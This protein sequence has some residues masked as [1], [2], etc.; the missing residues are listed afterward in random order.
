LHRIIKPDGEIYISEHLRDTANFIAF[1]IGFLHFYS[2]NTW[3]KTFSTA[4]LSLKKEIK[5][6]LFTSTF[7]LHKNGN[8]P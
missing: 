1:T 7:I 5:T 6:T 4:K 3:F 8:T 2:K